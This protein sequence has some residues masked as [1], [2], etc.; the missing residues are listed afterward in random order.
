MLC[1][2]VGGGDGGLVLR[3]VFMCGLLLQCVCCVVPRVVRRL[4]CVVACCVAI[5]V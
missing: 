1:V 2:V 3:C 5:E 4:V